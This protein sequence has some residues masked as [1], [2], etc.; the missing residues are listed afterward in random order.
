[1]PAWKY[2]ANWLSQKCWEDEVTTEGLQEKGNAK[3]RRNTKHETVDPFWEQDFEE[4]E[5]GEESA[6]E[7]SNVISLQRY[8]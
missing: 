7:S 1:V 4:P 5:C 3:C 6:F 8:R 2:P